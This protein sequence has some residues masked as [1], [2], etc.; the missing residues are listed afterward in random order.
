LPRGGLGITLACHSEGA[1]FAT[2]ESQLSVVETLRYAQGDMQTGNGS[3]EIVMSTNTALIEKRK[4][5]KRRLAAGEYKTLVDIFLEWFDRLLQKITRRS[6]PFPIW[7]ITVIL[8]VV[9]QIITY[10]GI[11]VA[12]D[13]D[14]VRSVAESYGLGYGMGLLI[15]ILSATGIIIITIV[16]N[17]YIARL[18]AL[19]RDGILDNTESMVSLNDFENWLKITGNWRLHL[20]VT[21]IL[22][23]LFNSYFLYLARDL[24][25]VHI[26]YGSV[27]SVFVFN[28]F[29]MIMFS[30]LIMVM[31]LSARLRRYDLKLFSADPGNSEIIS[32]LSG[33]LGIF[34]YLLAIF[35]AILTLGSSQIG[36]LSSFVFIL[37]ML[38]WLP[39]TILFI[40]NQTSL[41]SMIRRAKWKTL[42]EIQVK[43][44]KLQTSKNFGN[45]E[46]MDAVKRLMDYH[47][48]VKAT[49]DSALD[50][51][52]YLG[53]INSLL[54]PLLAFI[55]GNLDLVLKL[56]GMNP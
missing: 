21:V 53:F 31:L 1:F 15:N 10:T 16:I 42:N 17:K 7:L 18:F 38:L 26:G 25:G 55:L 14:A 13:W 6:G 50:F 46:T 20:F 3:P 54:L 8:C 51:R 35:A 37:V 56:F 36:L 44:E 40:L 19:W 22:N 24:F 34:I 9:V 30:Q 47:D 27:S 32:R 23:V 29:S 41:S 5:L 48:R 52:A 45:Q 43:V 33:E 11:Y 4:E 49:R 28:I 39:I 12:G 2:E